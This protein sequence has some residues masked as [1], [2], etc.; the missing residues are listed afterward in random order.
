[1]IGVGELITQQG[2]V[3][4]VRDTYLLPLSSTDRDGAS[5]DFNGDFF[6]VDADDL[7]LLLLLLELLELLLLLLLLLLVVDDEDPR[8]F[9]ATFFVLGL[10]N[11]FSFV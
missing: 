10:P 9:S 8:R 4:G 6:V 2:W 3:T 7:L 5:D 1:M 11:I